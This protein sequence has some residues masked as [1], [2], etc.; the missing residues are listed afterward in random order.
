MIKDFALDLAEIWGLLD[1]TVKLLCARNGSTLQHHK[2]QLKS[3]LASNIITC[4]NQLIKW[5]MNY[6]CQ[7]LIR[8]FLSQTNCMRSPRACKCVSLLGGHS[9]K[10]DVVTR[11][12]VHYKVITRKAVTGEA[13]K[14]QVRT[15]EITTNS[16]WYPTVKIF[17][18]N[19]TGELG[20]NLVMARGIMLLFPID[21]KR[22]F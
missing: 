12:P 4:S 21:V 16:N 9:P 11:S 7:I 15:G 19:L 17:P 3:F 1:V 14:V 2:H 8:K 22:R 6:W 5:L 10:E 13:V 20:N 18:N